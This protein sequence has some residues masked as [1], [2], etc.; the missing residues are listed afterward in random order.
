[1]ALLAKNPENIV[2]RNFAIKSD[3]TWLS[4]G[5]NFLICWCQLLELLC[6]RSFKQCLISQPKCFLELIEEN[7][8][9]ALGPVP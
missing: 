6:D 9:K 1:M 5:V 7:D 2:I 8:E 4:Q 3:N